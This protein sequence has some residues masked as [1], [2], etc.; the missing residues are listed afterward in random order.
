MDDTLHWFATADLRQYEDKYIS[1]VD[2][3]VVAA[4]EDPQVV[5]ETANRLHPGKE[6]VLWKVPHGDMC[7]FLA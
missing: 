4:D 7:V 1:I 5:W 6:A 2:K 3:E